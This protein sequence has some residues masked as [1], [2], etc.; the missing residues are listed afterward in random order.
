MSSAQGLLQVVAQSHWHKTY[1]FECNS[2]IFAGETNGD[3]MNSRWFS[4][5]R[6]YEKIT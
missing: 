5:G 4:H 6:I 2:R 3:G 1:G